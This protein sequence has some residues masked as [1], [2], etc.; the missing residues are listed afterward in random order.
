MGD[1]EFDLA[2]RSPSGEAVRNEERG[3]GEAEIGEGD[4]RCLAVTPESDAS[5]LFE[6]REKPM[7]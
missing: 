1:L 6:F 3:V 5:E 4:A 7:L 2:Y